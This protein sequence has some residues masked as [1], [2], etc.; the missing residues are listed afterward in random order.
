VTEHAAVGSGQLAGDG[1]GV[2]G[3]RGHER[4]TEDLAAVVELPTALVVGRRGEGDELV[5]VL[6]ADQWPGELQGDRERVAVLVGIGPNQREALDFVGLGLDRLAAD[7]GQLPG[8]FVAAARKDCHGGQHQRQTDSR[9]PLPNRIPN[10][11]HHLK[12]RRATHMAS[13]MWWRV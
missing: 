3:V 7:F 5:E 2:L 9:T 13:W 4:E 12:P 10:P 1:E 8:F 6:R 11:T